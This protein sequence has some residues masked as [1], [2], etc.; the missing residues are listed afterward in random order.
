MLLNIGRVF[1]LIIS[2][3][4]N[5]VSI[6]DIYSILNRAP[7]FSTAALAPTKTLQLEEEN[8]ENLL[9]V[10]EHTNPETEEDP[11]LE[12]IIQL[13]A[14]IKEWRKHHNIDLINLSP[15]L[16][17]KV[18]NKVYSQI[19]SSEKISNGMKHIGTAIGRVA[20]IFYATWFAFGSF[21]KGELFGLPNVVATNNINPENLVNFENSDN[22]TINVGPFTPTRAQIDNKKS[23]LY[24]NRNLF[25]QET[26]TI[27]YLLKDHPL[28]EWIE[29]LAKIKWPSHRAA[30]SALF[31]EFN[32]KE[33][34]RIPW[35]KIDD[36]LKTQ[37]EEE[38]L[39]ILNRFEIEFGSDDSIIKELKKR[40]SQLF[41]M[42][43]K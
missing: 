30:K 2:S 38:A 9:E 25:G 14:D 16:V 11:Q 39:N 21:E 10:Q 22:F 19:A 29:E 31:S 8:A 33:T 1:E 42:D 13:Q 35:V 26:R 6:E 23:E 34:S 27:S 7:F 3:I 18:F 12:L 15:W 41:K 5:P 17:Y 43:I 40:I 37:S 28:K 20:H 32:L 24:Y 4:V 36:S